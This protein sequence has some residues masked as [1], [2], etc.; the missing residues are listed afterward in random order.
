[1]VIIMRKFEEQ[2]ARKRIKKVSQQN[3]K[4]SI[5]R[6]SIRRD[7]VDDIMTYYGYQSS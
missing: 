1:M 2:E 4:I 7:V 6:I 5:E 3:Y